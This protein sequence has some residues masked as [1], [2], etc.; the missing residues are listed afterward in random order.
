[1]EKIWGDIGEAAGTA[2]Q[3]LSDKLSQIHDLRTS[4]G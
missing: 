3:S 4:L 2:E 1:M